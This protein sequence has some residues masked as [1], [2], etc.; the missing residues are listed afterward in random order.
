MP[1]KELSFNQKF[2]SYQILVIVLLALTQFTVVL[3]FMVMSPLGDILMKS[4]NMTT[5]QFGLVVSAYAFSAGIAG[6]LTA[7]FADRFD[8]KK[9]LLFFYIGFILGTLFCGLANTYPLLIAAR[10]ITGIFGGVIGSISMAIVADLF[11]PQQRGRVMGFLQMGFGSSQVLG[12]PISL[13]LANSFGWQSPFLMI[14]GLATLIWLI[15]IIK[16]K[17]ITQHLEVKN[18]RNALHHLLHTIAQKDYRIGFMSTALLSLGGFMMM[19]WGSAFA[20]NNL[21]VTPDQLP[22]LFMIAGIATLII[23]PIIGKLS[24]KMDKFNLFAIASVWMICVVLVYTRL[25]LVPFWFVIIMNVLMMIGIMSRMVPSMAL[26]SSLPKMQ[27]RGAFMSINSSLQQIAGGVAAAIG[28]MIV[29]Q[30]DKTSPL[31]HY[32]TLGILITII[33]L[34]AIYM[35]YRVSKIVKRREIETAKL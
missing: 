4:M 31:E 2:S 16:M 15:I 5:T 12:I 1:Q 28:G 25:T 10:I 7:G 18:D 17:P 9:L 33:L 22:I 35:V 34:F 20:I 30:K 21:H 3:D 27:D 14:V 8:R 32:D 24:D 23:M 13:Y 26:A 6:I 19:P 11:L 29:V